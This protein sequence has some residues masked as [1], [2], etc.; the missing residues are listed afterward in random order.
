MK[1]CMDAMAVAQE[2]AM[3]KPHKIERIWAW[4]S[5]DTSGEDGIIA[6][7]GENGAIPLIGSD[8]ERIES[9]RP[10]VEKIAQ[11]SGR[12]ITLRAFGEMKTLETVMP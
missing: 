10:Y 8:M 5:S 4:V 11:A 6:Y 2:E 12:P 3:A 7:V 9:F 1:P